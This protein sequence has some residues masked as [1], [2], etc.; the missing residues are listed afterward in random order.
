MKQGVRLLEPGDPDDDGAGETVVTTFDPRDPRS[1]E[2]ARHVL[3]RRLGLD[4]L[5]SV[6]GHEL[7]WSQR[8]AARAKRWLG[9]HAAKRERRS[10]SG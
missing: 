1:V 5:P 4:Y 9:G 6:C 7:T 2:D 8:L 10:G 3:Q